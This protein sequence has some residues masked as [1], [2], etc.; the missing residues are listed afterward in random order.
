M[1]FKEIYLKNEEQK[2]ENT[3]II[4][5]GELISVSPFFIFEINGVRYSSEHFEVYIEAGDR[6]QE[7]EEVWTEGHGYGAPARVT[8]KTGQGDVLGNFEI[9]PDSTVNKKYKEGDLISVIDRGNSFIV[10]SRVYKLN[11][12]ITNCPW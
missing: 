5:I 7:Y 12:G 9:V 6:I 10:L 4:E 1:S 2:N 8:H 3:N 11:G